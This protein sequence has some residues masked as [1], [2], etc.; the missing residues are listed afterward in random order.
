MP[1]MVTG[2]RRAFAGVRCRTAAAR[3]LGQAGLVGCAPVVNT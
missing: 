3:I 1:V 2:V